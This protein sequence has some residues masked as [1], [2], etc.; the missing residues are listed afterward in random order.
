VRLEPNALSATRVSYCN[1]PLFVLGTPEVVFIYPLC[2]D[3]F[4]SFRFMNSQ[5]FSYCSVL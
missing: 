5:A 1:M 3:L 2:Y 4:I